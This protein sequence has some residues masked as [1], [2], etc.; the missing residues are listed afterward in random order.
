METQ[1]EEV[2]NTTTNKSAISAESVSI[3]LANL[4]QVLSSIVVD[5]NS[6]LAIIK[7]M[8]HTTKETTNDSQG[9]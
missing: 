6:Q 7:S 5:I 3:Y 8:S 9:N 2:A 4:A 1:V